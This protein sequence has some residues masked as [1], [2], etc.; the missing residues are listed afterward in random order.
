MVI[1]FI[2]KKNK[3][4][5]HKGLLDHVA[6]AEKKFK[7]IKKKRKESSKKLS[8]KISKASKKILIL[9]CTQFLFFY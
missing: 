5:T 2:K 7:E 8:S 6:N 1:V 9:F 4:H 3:A